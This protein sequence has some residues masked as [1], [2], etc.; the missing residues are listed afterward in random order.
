MEQSSKQWC[1]ATKN[2]KCVSKK[3]KR[4]INSKEDTIGGRN[5]N[6]CGNRVKKRE[7]IKFGTTT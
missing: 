1:K 6:D 5:Q 7:K 2:N 4:K 3:E